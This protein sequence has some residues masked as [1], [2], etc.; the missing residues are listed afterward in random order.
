[1]KPGHK[2]S[3]LQGREKVCYI[4]G[5][6]DGLHRHHIFGGQRRAISDKNGFWVWVVGEWHN[7]APYSIHRNGWELRRKLQSE[8]QKKYLESHTMEEW[9]ELMGKNYMEGEK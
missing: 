4:T 5:R 2:V 8:C 6:T 9:M 7:L 3:I 1:M